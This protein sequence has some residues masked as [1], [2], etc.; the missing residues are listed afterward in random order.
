[1]KIIT[2][3]KSPLWRRSGDAEESDVLTEFVEDPKIIEAL[4]ISLEEYVAP[5]P[6]VS[7]CV[8]VNIVQHYTHFLIYP[9]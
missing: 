8:F 6:S 5:T 1:M 4:A 3:D 7:S 2:D 9:W